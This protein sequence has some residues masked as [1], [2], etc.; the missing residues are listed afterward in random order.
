MGTRR[1]PCGPRSLA[2]QAKTRIFVQTAILLRS[3]PLSPGLAMTRIERT[4][5]ALES[6]VSSE[7]DS[8]AF[9]TVLVISATESPAPRKASPT[10]SDSP[11]GMLT[12][13]RMLRTPYRLA[14][15]HG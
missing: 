8:R 11:G 13:T 7:V 12:S 15:P 3:A 5:G 2:V 14:V 1:L 9:L 10:G 6:I 4:Y